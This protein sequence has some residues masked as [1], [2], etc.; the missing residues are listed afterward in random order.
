MLKTDLEITPEPPLNYEKATVIQN[1]DKFFLVYSYGS[2]LQKVKEDRNYITEVY[3][4][5]PTL[6]SGNPLEWDRGSTIYQREIPTPEPDLADEMHDYAV[7]LYS[8]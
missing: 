2:S 4:I 1:K 8:K 7:S 6:N 5:Y 3:Q